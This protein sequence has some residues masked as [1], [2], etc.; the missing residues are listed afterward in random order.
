VSTGMPISGTG[1]TLRSLL[2]LPIPARA[3]DINVASPTVVTMRATIA[4]AKIASPPHLT[5]FSSHHTQINRKR[6]RTTIH[7]TMLAPRVTHTRTQRTAEVKGSNSPQPTT[8][9]ACCFHVW[10]FLALMIWI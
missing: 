7:F 9:S 8:L 5:P 10:P 2:I 4:I 1:P 6:R 3:P